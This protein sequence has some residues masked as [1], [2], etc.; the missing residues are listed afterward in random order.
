VRGV[1][2]DL[3]WSTVRAAAAACFYWPGSSSW[4]ATP[5]HFC[6][7]AFGDGASV[8]RKFIGY[9]RLTAVKGQNSRITLIYILI[10]EDDLSDQA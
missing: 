4:K 10:P 6:K 7:N 1:C 5:G 8:P 9:L 2:L 3:T